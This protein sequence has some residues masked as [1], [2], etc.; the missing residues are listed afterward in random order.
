MTRV[1]KSSSRENGAHCDERLVTILGACQDSSRKW[2]NCILI[3][4]SV[5]DPL[6]LLRRHFFSNHPHGIG[7][8]RTCHS[9]ADAAKPCFQYRTPFPANRAMLLLMSV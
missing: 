5:C 2:I 4:L 1:G 8:I 6:L 3:C 7:F 9:K